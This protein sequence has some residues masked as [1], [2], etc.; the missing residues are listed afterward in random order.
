[1]CGRKVPKNL[2]RSAFSS[3]GRPVLCPYCEKTFVDGP[4]KF[5]N[6]VEDYAKRMYGRRGDIFDV[7]DGIEGEFGIRPS[8]F[9]IVHWVK[10]LDPE[11]LVLRTP[12]PPPGLAFLFSKEAVERARQMIGRGRTY[13][14]VQRAIVDLKDE[15]GVPSKRAIW[16]WGRTPSYSGE[17]NPPDVLAGREFGA[18]ISMSNLGE[19]GGE[20]SP[21]SLDT[22][23][24]SVADLLED[25]LPLTGGPSGLLRVLRIRFTQEGEVGDVGR[26]EI[27]LGGDGSEFFNVHIPAPPGLTAEAADRRVFS[28]VAR[29]LFSHLVPEFWV[30]LDELRDHCLSIPTSLFGEAGGEGWKGDN[31]KF[32]ENCLGSIHSAYCRSRSDGQPAT[33][34]ARFLEELPR[35]GKGLNWVRKIKGFLA[36]HSLPAE[37]SEKFGALLGEVLG[38][39]SLLRT[40]LVPELDAFDIKY[41]EN[42]VGRVRLWKSG[43]QIDRLVK[44]IDGCADAPKDLL[45]VFKA[46]L[47]FDTAHAQLPRARDLESGEEPRGVR[48]PHGRECGGAG[49][50]GEPEEGTVFDPEGVNT[51]LIEFQ[52]AVDGGSTANPL[53]VLGKLVRVLNE[54]HPKSPGGDLVVTANY[55]QN[56]LSAYKGILRGLIRMR[57][58]GNL[59]PRALELV[60]RGLAR[61]SQ[62]IEAASTSD[63][64][65]SRALLK[66][67]RGE[68]ERIRGKIER[69]LT[70]VNGS[71]GTLEFYTKMAGQGKE[72]LLKSLDD[73]P[74][75]ATLDDI[76]NS[77]GFDNESALQILEALRASG[78]VH[79]TWVA[80]S[81]VK[82]FTEPLGGT[83]ALDEA[84]GSS[85]FAE[86]ALNGE[87][88]LSVP[89]SRLWDLPEKDLSKYFRRALK[90]ALRTRGGSGIRGSA[91]GSRAGGPRSVASLPPHN[92]TVDAYYRAVKGAVKERQS[93]FQDPRILVRFALKSKFNPVIVLRAFFDTFDGNLAAWE[94]PLKLVANYRPA[95]PVRSFFKLV[96]SRLAETCPSIEVEKEVG[97]A[98]HQLERRVQFS[99]T[100]E[101]AVLACLQLRDLLA[102]H[103]APSKKLLR[104]EAHYSEHLS[105]EAKAARDL[106]RGLLDKEGADKFDELA[107][108]LS[109]YKKLVDVLSER[110]RAGT[111][112]AGA[113][114]RPQKPGIWRKLTG[115]LR[116]KTKRAVPGEPGGQAGALEGGG[117][118]KGAA[119]VRG[120]VPLE[121]LFDFEEIFHLGPND[122][123]TFISVD[124]NEK[125]DHA[126]LLTDAVT[127][128][129]RDLYS[130]DLASYNLARVSVHLVDYSQFRQI[131]ERFRGQ[132]PGDLSWSFFLE[133]GNLVCAWCNWLLDG[134]D[135]L[136]SVERM[137]RTND[138]KK[139]LVHEFAH[140][141]YTWLDASA[142][143]VVRAS[144]PVAAL[145]PGGGLGATYGPDELP[146][147]LFSFA[148]E[149]LYEYFLYYLVAPEGRGMGPLSFRDFL[150]VQ[151]EL[152]RIQPGEWASLSADE[153]RDLRDYYYFE[154]LYWEGFKV[155]A[156]SRGHGQL[157][158][159][160]LELVAGIPAGFSVA[161]A[162]GGGN[163]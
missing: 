4:V 59:P 155:D 36:G 50:T 63:K 14:Q 8:V 1:N 123:E 7:Q 32:F 29:V 104:R 111:K 68:L 144:S 94:V 83:I 61:S 39:F 88:P 109:H 122:E 21:A 23:L 86:S 133:Q 37:L 70:A 6:E 55:L 87:T 136:N 38:G 147:E 27:T 154:G 19:F 110:V 79:P 96:A 90:K 33:S 45:R 85:E 134:W 113:P 42:R 98:L 119:A 138:F 53:E 116:R 76:V 163:A 101:R 60:L 30:A 75:G 140:W 127:R 64:H 139:Y 31:F 150:D 28:Q 153:L 158:A 47:E 58:R 18:E 66:S 54:S 74:S 81:R 145:L 107:D 26:E 112:Q 130:L 143:A 89:D 71:A 34:F 142:R 149:F 105:R 52:G 160:L 16:R 132:P 43:D 35:S 151:V 22:L 102:G 156:Y 67:V 51:L 106:Y 13:R 114:E 48:E 108:L 120:H 135:L 84:Q 117:R 10:E 157:V 72:K 77:T 137:G 91:G 92:V 20:N 15:I 95:I 129:F 24:F 11:A 141:T 124:L 128:V 148:V 40:N 25:F 82:F 44:E 41:R 97:A 161:G 121:E 125:W 152:I 57:L 65:A 103:G 69:N 118:G 162:S 93:E 56:V 100:L 73:M 17:P 46:V 126:D 131:E 49:V 5:A 146:D 12:T 3:A 99:P 80:G 159:G 115:A 62:L 9:R 78:A 2:I